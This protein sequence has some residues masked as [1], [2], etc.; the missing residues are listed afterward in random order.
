MGQ[1][2]VLT[3]TEG[4]KLIEWDRSD[5]A[6]VERAQKRFDELTGKGYRAYQVSRD[7]QR[8]GNPVSEFNPDAGELILAPPM[9]GGR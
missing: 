4:D 3:P 8:T 5:S 6:S 7:P 1:M 2:K 9:A